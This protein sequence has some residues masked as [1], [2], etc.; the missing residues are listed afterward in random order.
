MKV[1]LDGP[2]VGVVTI[3]WGHALAGHVLLIDLGFARFDMGAAEG[4]DTVRRQIHP[5]SDRGRSIA[6]VRGPFRDTG[7]KPIPVPRCCYA[8][9]ML[10]PT[11]CGGPGVPAM[12]CLLRGARG[13]VAAKSHDVVGWFRGSR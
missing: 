4:G 11:P 2:T 9:G 3:L 13:P 6:R 10:V 1:A 12:P 8:G 7:G 5:R